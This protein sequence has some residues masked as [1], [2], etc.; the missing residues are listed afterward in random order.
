MTIST[1][2]G[3]RFPADAERRS[4]V[5]LDCSKQQSAH[6]TILVQL[7]LNRK[8]VSPMSRRGSGFFL[9]LVLGAVVGATLAILFA[10]QEGE[11]TRN[12][13]VEQ[14]VDIRKRTEGTLDQLSGQ[15]KER[16]NDA[17]ATGRETYGR[18]KEELSARYNRAKTGEY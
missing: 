18:V 8:E 6:C 11:Q 10:P 15:A 9:G 17:L 4:P 1:S 16:F 2:A 13:L 12:L 3:K 7:D 14:G 5:L